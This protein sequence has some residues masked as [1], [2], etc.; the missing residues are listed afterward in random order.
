MY[1][2]DVLGE[3]DGTLFMNREMTQRYSHKIKMPMHDLLV[4][5]QISAG[6]DADYSESE[7]ISEETSVTF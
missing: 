7:N 3:Y 1:H 4:Y 2:Q 5:V 6:G